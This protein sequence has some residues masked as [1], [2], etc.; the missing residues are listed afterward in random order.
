MGVSAC[1]CAVLKKKSVSSFTCKNK[2]HTHTHGM[3]ENWNDWKLSFKLKPK[4]VTHE[5]Y[6][7]HVSEN[8]VRLE[9]Y[10]PRCWHCDWIRLLLQ[11][12]PWRNL[13]C[14][15]VLTHSVS[16]HALNCILTNIPKN[17]RFCT[18]FIVSGFKTPP[19]K[20]KCSA[21]TSPVLS[22]SP[23]RPHVVTKN[24]FWRKQILKKSHLTQRLTQKN[25]IW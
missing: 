17:I 4:N 16:R 22:S 25:C 7:N 6:L 12:N 15:K 13:W 8:I 1:F 3:W 10:E 5:W 20:L 14:T 23:P 2:T 9:I 21:Q 24:I 18:R 19:W 11:L